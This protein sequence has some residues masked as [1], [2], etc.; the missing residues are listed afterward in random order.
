MKDDNSGCSMVS[1]CLTW[2]GLIAFI[3]GY[4]LENVIVIFGGVA[5]LIVFGIVYNVIENIKK[6]NLQLK[7][8]RE[9][10]EVKRLKQV[11]TENKNKDLFDFFKYD[12]KSL[13][14]D[15]NTLISSSYNDISGYPVKRYQFDLAEE[16][17]RLIISEDF[18]CI[19]K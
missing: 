1:G 6:K 8:K 18:P 15:E 4:A 3:V 19:E 14:Y 10:E 2:L 16:K 13:P 17:L 12:L 11:S 7:W 5:T 9:D